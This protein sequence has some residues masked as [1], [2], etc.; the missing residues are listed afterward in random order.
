MYRAQMQNQY[1]SHMITGRGT[2]SQ[3]I[4]TITTMCIGDCLAVSSP[5]SDKILLLCEEE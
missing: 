4:G 2:I 3:G 5:S 1:N